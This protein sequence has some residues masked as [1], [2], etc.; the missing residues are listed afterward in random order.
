MLSME[1]CVSP[2]SAIARFGV[3]ICQHSRHQLSV[4]DFVVEVEARWMQ[5]VRSVVRNRVAAD[6]RRQPNAASD[7]D[8]A[9]GGEDTEWVAQEAADLSATLND[10]MD[11]EA[12]VDAAF[13]AAR[14]AL[15]ETCIP[16]GA[17]RRKQ[18]VK[19]AQVLVEEQVCR[20]L[21]TIKVIRRLVKAAEA[22]AP[23]DIAPTDKRCESW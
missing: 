13:P 19:A 14:S 8:A 3:V 1:T 23:R 7:E 10:A 20:G 11:I 16:A 21:P 18:K 5:Q 6:R 4:K 9:W 12:I 15:I 2:G 22:V 17:P